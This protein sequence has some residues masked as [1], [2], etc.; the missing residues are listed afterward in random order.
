[1]F[2]TGVEDKIKNGLRVSMDWLGFTIFNVNSPLEVIE[3]LG[4]K[5]ED[6]TQ[7]PKGGMGYKSILQ[8]NGYTLQIL[9]DGKE[10]M[11]IHVNISGSSIVEVVKTFMETRKI[12]T[13]FGEAYDTF[14]TALVTFL[15]EISACARFTRVDLAVDDLGANFYKLDELKTIL[16]KNDEKYKIV[17]KFRNWQEICKRELTG[18]KTGQTIYM[19]SRKSETF[20]RVYDKR[21]EQMNKGSEDLGIDWIRWELELKKERAEETVNMIIERGEIGTIFTGV[22]NN[23][24]RIVENTDS[25]VSRCPVS[26]LWEKFVSTVEKIRLYVA[27][28]EKTLEEKE[29]WFKYQV[30]PTLAG[31]IVSKMGDMGIVY[32]YFTDYLT[33]MSKDMRNICDR[34]NPTWR[35]DWGLGD[36]CIA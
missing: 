3:L 26:S 25:N 6:F 36:E 13:V 20:L 7:L 2:K 29:N 8:L 11:G 23:Y 34:Y 14:D 12:N 28:A 24:V 4:Y 9:Y 27:Q 19:G 33:R 15:K 10:D 32:D 1:M 31:I 17:S 18:K 22:L 21:L 16:E 35:E 30:A 5:E